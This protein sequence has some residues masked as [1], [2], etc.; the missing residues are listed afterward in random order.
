[1]LYS[2]LNK[3]MISNSNYKY[4]D[5]DECFRLIREYGMLPNIVR[6]S[7]QVRNVSVA[8]YKHLISNDSVSLKLI[9]ASALLHD[10]AKTDSLDHKEIRHDITGGEILRKLGYD[11]IAVIVENHV[12]FTGFDPDGPVTE[13]E[14]IY[15]ADKRVMH[16][17]IVDIE[18]MVID[19]VDRYGGDERIRGL[20]L[21]NK[22]FVLALENKIQSRMDME[23]DLALADI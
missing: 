16:D 21:E 14:I 22:K 15:Y 23:I 10:I 6:H 2:A 19:L 7:I 13:K 17:R 8:I 5:E 18:T 11:D 4:P 3:K 1:M 12:V 9:I 20:I